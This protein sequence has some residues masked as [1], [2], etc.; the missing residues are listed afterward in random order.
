MTVLGGGGVGA[1][2]AL[3]NA[4]SKP[5]DLQ[6]SIKNDLAL[7]LSF[8]IDII[9]VLHVIREITDYITI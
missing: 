7:P 2:G 8:R 9:E 1:P 6:M 3:Q 5:L 4:V